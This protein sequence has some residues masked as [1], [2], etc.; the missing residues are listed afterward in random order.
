MPAASSRAR[1][2]PILLAQAIGFLCGVAS[3]KLNSHLIPPAELGFYGVFLTFAPV[4][5]WVVNAGLL[6]FVARHWAGA[7]A[8]WAFVVAVRRGWQRRLPWLALLTLLGAAA[9]ARPEMAGFA[10][11]WPLLFV[12]A[13]L[14]AITAL[15]QNA[16]QAARA[17]WRDCGVAATAAIGRSF[18]PPLCFA[19][20]GGIT[21]MLIGFTLHA[22]IAALVAGWAVRSLAGRDSGPTTGQPIL[23]GA[24]D[25]WLFTVL[26]LASWTVGAMNRWIVAWR[27]G[28]EQA[29]YFTLTGGAAVIVTSILGTA[30]M[31]YVQPGLF[32]LGDAASDERRVLARR[33]DL[34]AA[35]YAAGAGAALFALH[36]VFPALVGPLVS[37][38]YRDALVWVA[39]AGCFG[40]AT[41]VAT[42]YHI[43]LLA[44][45]RE[46][47][48]GPVDLGT[49]AVLI[50][51]SVLAALQG[52][53]WFQRWLL[54]TP[55]LPWI[56]TRPLARH[57]LLRPS[58]P[59]APAPGR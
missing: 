21:S 47:D 37:P 32:A 10:R 9:F 7:G 4:G 38:A 48:C 41:M 12:A 57:F 35:A 16:L 30:I 40:I 58:A 59:P 43:M 39:P 31:Q 17:H 20:A 26:A 11:V 24:Y 36:L 8:S 44:G 49:A 45:R 46:R 56:L 1:L 33:A 15:A 52:I 3:V 55:V 18:L 19:L 34:A 28:D 6:K 22:L 29:G 2:L 54:V 50:A 14:L 23:T 42:F 13:A 51:G 5:M 25:G 53:E 27:F